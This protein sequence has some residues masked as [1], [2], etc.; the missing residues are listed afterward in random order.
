MEAARRASKAL[1]FSR[2]DP[3]PILLGT[4]LLLTLDSGFR[5]VSVPRRGRVSQRDQ[6]LV[7][8]GDHA[9]VNGLFVA[10]G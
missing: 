1:R 8:Q 5:P 6:A 4:L 9:I 10:V 7:G 2:R 3:E